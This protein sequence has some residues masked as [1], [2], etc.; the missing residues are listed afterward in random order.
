MN[1]EINTTNLNSVDGGPEDITKSLGNSNAQPII[2]QQSSRQ[3]FWILM[4]VALG[5]LL[6]ILACGIMFTFLSFGAGLSA[7]ADGGSS[8]GSLGSGPAVAIVRVEGVIVG[9]DDS[10][11]LNGAGSGTVIADLKSAK[12]DEDV[13]AIVLRV[14]SPGGTVTGSAQIHEYI[15]DEFTKPVVVS[16]ASTAASG[17]YYVSAPAD[18]IFAR[19]DT[20]TGSL[21]VI[22]SLLNFS[23]FLDEWGVDV[24]NVASG[25]NKAIGSPYDE[26]SA[27]HLEIL[28]ALIDESYD[29]FVQ[30]IV[31]GRGLEEATVREIADGR[32]Y[33]GKQA[34]AVGLVDEL[35]N[36]TDAVAHAAD[37]GGITDEP[38]II[39][40]ERTPD[41][42]DL[43][44]T[45][46]QA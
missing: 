23:E 1:E 33:S 34:M 6:P 32:I 42:T 3:G 20:T 43:L 11:Y 25:P 10:N 40:Y 29:Q 18:Y 46:G 8:S 26:I 4:G 9:T 24:V 14:D 27:E 28:D 38:R 22:M 16:M 35:G 13:K 37:L 19:A 36:F 31:D 30:I 12:E 41:F 15:R 17:G 21:G 39:E 45:F 2:I 5:F 44:T 7:V